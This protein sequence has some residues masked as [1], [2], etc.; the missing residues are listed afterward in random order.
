MNFKYIFS[1]G[2][3]G[4]CGPIGPDGNDGEKGEKCEDVY[5]SILG[6]KVSLISIKS[7]FYFLKKYECRVKQEQKVKRVT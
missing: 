2:D 5:I 1:Q 7:L 6:I 3:K 4:N